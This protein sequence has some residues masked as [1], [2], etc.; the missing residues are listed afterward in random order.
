MGG[1]SDGIFGGSLIWIII[2]IVILML[3]CGRKD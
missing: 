1:T 2:A 3:L